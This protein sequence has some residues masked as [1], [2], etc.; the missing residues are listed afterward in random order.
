MKNRYGFSLIE[1]LVVV[2]IIGVLSAVG[3]VAFNGYTS[4]AKKQA[5]KS[6]HQT[7]IKY[8]SAELQKCNLGESKF[9]ENTINCSDR[10][11]NYKISQGA[12]VVLNS[13]FKNPYKTNQGMP[14]HGS[15]G[16]SCS[17]NVMGETKVENKNNVLRIQTC[18]DDTEL[19]SFQISIE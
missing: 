8:F 4:G 13:K 5:A 12:E 18:V 7:L 16:F 6:N 1:L 17:Q 2:A 15:L 11:T 9:I 14:Q 10:F 19:L 3:V